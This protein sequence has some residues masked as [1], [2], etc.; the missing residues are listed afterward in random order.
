MERK[1]VEA[2][3]IKI[4]GISSIGIYYNLRQPENEAF[5]ISLYEIDSLL[6]QRREP[7]LEAKEP[8]IPDRYTEFADVFSKEASDV[9]PPYR[10][11]N[12]KI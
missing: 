5:T 4:T 8:T 12:Y 1:P 7:P 9:L 11:Y 10:S 3:P 6:E 2:P